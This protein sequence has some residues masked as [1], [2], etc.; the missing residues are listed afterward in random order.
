MTI[1]G[2]LPKRTHRT[3]WILAG[4]QD[5]EITKGLYTS[6]SS[7]SFPTAI[8]FTG[9]EIGFQDPA[10][11]TINSA[12]FSPEAAPDI[13]MAW[14]KNNDVSPFHQIIVLPPRGPLDP[15]GATAGINNCRIFKDG[16][17]C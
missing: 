3:I 7:G 14:K 16:G 11:D 9:V 1:S 10:D 4:I 13:G 6:Y 17:R 2:C 12:N 15:Q 5:F 8:F